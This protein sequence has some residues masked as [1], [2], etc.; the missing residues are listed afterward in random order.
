MSGV[1]IG[2]LAVYQQEL[3]RGLLPA[4]LWRKSGNQGDQWQEAE[5]NIKKYRQYKVTEFNVIRA[6][7]NTLPIGH[8]QV[9]CHAS[10]CVSQS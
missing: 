5:V 3:G 10:K 7:Y 2:S 8:Q 4:L 1:G 9:T 6:K